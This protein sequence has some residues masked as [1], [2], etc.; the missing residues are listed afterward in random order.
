M[1]EWVTWAIQGAVAIVIGILGFLWKQDRKHVDE[2]LAKHDRQI[3]ELQVEAQKAPMVYALREDFIR[4]TERIDQ[5]LD[6]LIA[7]SG[8]KE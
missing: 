7:R 4:V 6:R 3:A 1:H 5:K 2:K 8:T